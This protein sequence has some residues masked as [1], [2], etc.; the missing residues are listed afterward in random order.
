[1]LADPS[2]S[3]SAFLSLWEKRFGDLTSAQRREFRSRKELS[4]ILALPRNI[5]LVA[6]SSGPQ[7]TDILR[8]GRKLDDL[9]LAKSQPLSDYPESWVRLVTKYEKNP[10][11][12]RR[13]LSFR[14]SLE[15]R[16][17]RAHK[18]DLKNSFERAKLR[19]GEQALEVGIEI[20]GEPFYG[21]SFLYVR[22]RLGISP[23]SEQALDGELW[24]DPDNPH[25]LSGR[26]VKVVI[27]ARTVGYLPENLAPGV[28]GLLEPEGGHMKVKLRVWFDLEENVPQQNSV[29]IL[30]KTESL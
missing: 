6:L 2:V 7:L 26:A 22:R 15:E 9:E 29:R 20:V 27:E 14:A 11:M 28:F 18:G 19:Q 16:Y 24:N 10:R 21:P 13:A 4:G 17:G 1:M 5:L 25:S 23:G 12:I 30:G 3:V 8:E